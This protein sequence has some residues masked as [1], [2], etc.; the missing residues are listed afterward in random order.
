MASTVAEP[1]WSGARG[2]A[3]LPHAFSAAGPPLLFGLRLW[4]SVCLAFYVAFWL[5][6]DNAF[7]AGTSAAIVC[8]PQLGAS[9]RKGWFRMIGTLVGATIIVVLTA[10]FPQERIAFLALLALWCGLCVF[11]ATLLTNFASYAASLAGYTAALIA[12]ETLG[13]TGGP[14]SG[15]FMLAITRASEICIGIAC[16]GIVLAGTDLGSAG[17]RL[18]ADL[19]DLA[20]EITGRLTGMLALAGQQLP[21]MRPER[22][23]VLRRVIALDPVIDQ[24]I[25]ESSD[26]RYRAPMLQRTVHGLFNALEGWRGVATRLARLPDDTARGQAE[27]ILRRIPSE[28]GSA[29][30]PGA[31]GQWLAEPLVL[32]RSCEQAEQAL[33]SLPAGTPSLRLLADETAKTMVGI[34]R[35]LDGLALLVHAAGRSFGGRRGFRP[36]VPDELP[37]LLNAARALVT[38]VLVEVWWVVTAWPNGASAF[39]IAAV[40]LLLLSPKGD[41]APAG[42][43]A[44]IL[45]VSASILAAALIKF[46]VLPALETFPA[47]CLALGLFLVPVGFCVARFHAPAAVAVLTVM[48]STFMPLV[49]PT[50]QMTYDTQQFYNLALAIF[51]GCGAVAL[52]F[53]LLPPLSP[54]FRTRRLLAFAL[55]DL[56]R[57]AIAPLPLSL[58]DWEE[59]MYGRLVA[60]PDAAEP[61]AQA[62]LLA[63][64]AVGSALIRLRSMVSLFALGPQLDAALAALAQ[65]DSAIATSRLHQLDDQLAALPVAEPGSELIM[66]ARASI[67]VIAEALDQH[68]AYFDAGVRA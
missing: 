40:V 26:L 25:G 41:L 59:R 49:S 52:S 17:R 18:A 16:A 62:Q 44:V 6:L 46:A 67:L 58:D 29:R 14:D 31:P 34:S 57:S 24:A 63:A 11:A 9:L 3:G 45:G 56:R 50:N 19:A 4:A 43:L 21:D 32:R 65:G 39:F 55:L 27:T 37:A 54:V 1:G 66:R 38:I 61:A 42:A 10:C 28:L 15:V 22:R 64:L 13:A 5:E 12:A 68:A 51:V 36:T 7:W 47:F 48:A 53:H 33:L 8:L 23:A 60:L 2:T 20:A 30:S 35:V